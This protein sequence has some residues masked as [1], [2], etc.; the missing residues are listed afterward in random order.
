[1]KSGNSSQTS[2][3]QEELINRLEE[4]RRKRLQSSE[5]RA[6]EK[7]A[8]TFTQKRKRNKQRNAGENRNRK[9][10]QEQVNQKKPIEQSLEGQ[11]YDL[12]SLPPQPNTRQT[13]RAEKQ[14]KKKSPNIRTNEANSLL[15]QLSNSEKLAQT[16]ALSEILSKPV[17]LRKRRL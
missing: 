4:I 12:T 1:M 9:P 2:K 17:E 16:I 10:V 5:D 3:Q 13:R 15:E 11:S 8:G 6:D 14:I 7:R